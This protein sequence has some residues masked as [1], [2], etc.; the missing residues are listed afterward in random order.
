MLPGCWLS[1][2]AECWCLSKGRLPPWDKLTEADSG[3]GLW[4]SPR[5]WA[6]VKRLLVVVATYGGV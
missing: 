5:D 1:S 3:G 4:W 2:G 6:E